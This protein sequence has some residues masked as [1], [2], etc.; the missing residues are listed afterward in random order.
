MSREYRIIAKNR[1][2]KEVSIATSDRLR[3]LFH[4]EIFQA[5]SVYNEVRIIYRDQ[6]YGPLNWSVMP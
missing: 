4:A 5:K 3:A 2:G 1:D 6:E